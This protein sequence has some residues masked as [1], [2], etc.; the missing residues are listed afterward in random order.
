MPSGAN[1]TQEGSAMSGQGTK[2]LDWL[3]DLPR[4]PGQDPTS[5]W[6]ERQGLP[7]TR[8]NFLE[9]A[10]MAEPLGPEEEA[11]LPNEIRRNP[12]V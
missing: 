8:A 1:T 6:L 5:N 2:S 9:A 11:S 7:L 12:A 10:G 4:H 3:K